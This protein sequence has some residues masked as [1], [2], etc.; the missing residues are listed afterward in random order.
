[1]K[2]MYILKSFAMKA[3]V[4]RVMSDKMNYLA[5]H[6]YD[7]VLV[8]YEQGNHP[9][10]FPLHQK[11]V[12]HS[13]DARFFTLSRYPIWKRPYYWHKMRHR[14]KCGLQ[15]VVDN[16]KPDVMITTTYSMK[17]L[18]IILGV[19]TSAHRL[20]ESHIA[21]YTVRKAYDYRQHAFLFQLARLYDK[22]VF[23]K[24][25]RF[26]RLVVL[27][28]GDAK[29]WKEYIDNVD[30]IPN[31]VTNYPDEVMPH[32]ANGHRIIAA[33]RLHEQKGFDML[34][35]AFAQIADLCSE[36]YLD[37]YGHGDDE[38]LLLDIINTNSLN[39]KVRILP[40]TSH[41]YEEY[42]KSEFYVL[43]SRYEGYPLVLNEAMS[44]GIP[45][46]AFR[47]KYGP[48]DAIEHH[49]NGLLVENGN[50]NELAQQI[51]WMTLHVKERLAMGHAARLAAK[52]YL[53]ETIM[54]NWIEL[55][56]SLM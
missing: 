30:I 27:T 12:H 53:P 20:I 43:S 6:G 10:A 26:E 40:P 55:F 4:E 41:I 44:C 52:R 29:D 35:N 21:C 33:G 1:M 13:L 3:G 19:N 45:C 7:V 14:L 54:Q 18:D 49:V 11:V 36:W 51:L 48:E 2:I 25:R 17:V 5:A 16:E 24:I 22:Y 46:V 42:Q 56:N 8:T 28:A 31:P 47:C 39:G 50:T 15:E 9:L 38:Q 37:I 34:I 32:D 23:R